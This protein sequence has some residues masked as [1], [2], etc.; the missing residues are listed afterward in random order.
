M[1]SRM[2]RPV[3]VCSALFAIAQ[4]APAQSKVAVINLQTAVFESA[5]IKKADAEMPARFKTAQDDLDKLQKEIAAIAQQLHNANSKLTPAQEN[6]LQQQGTR[7]QRDAQRKQE[8]LQAA[9]QAYRNEILS[10]SSQKMN[11]VVKKIAE[12]K[13]LDLV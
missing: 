2:L 8:D 11:A 10:Q 6:D 4:I 9:A 3:L 1:F 12:E 7:K 13:G 5:E